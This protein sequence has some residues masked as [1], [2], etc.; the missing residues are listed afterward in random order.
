MNGLDGRVLPPPLPRRRERWWLHALLLGL[1]FCTTTFIGAGFAA[2]FDR[3]LMPRA[4]AGID[5]F[6]RLFAGGLLYSL[7]L[8]AILVSHEMGHYLVCRHYG[9]DASPP[10]FIPVPVVLGT[11]G[12]FIRIREPLRTKRH[13]FDMG[14]AGPIAGFVVTLPI[15]VYG[16]AQTHPAPG[17]GTDAGSTLYQYPLLVTIFQKLLFGT[18]YTSAEVFEHPTFMAGWAGLFVTAFNLIPLSQLDG[19]HA[20]YAVAGRRT[21]LFAFPVLAALLVLGIKFPSWWVLSVLVLIF[22]LKHPP[23][24][25]E[26]APLSPGRKLVA[27]CGLLML[28][29]SFIP[30]PMRQIFSAPRLPKERGGPVVHQLDLHRGAKHAG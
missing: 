5:A 23:V 9:I 6:G 25:D 28:V 19:G 29:L 4:G 11:M 20:L 13:V 21:Q 26:D 10:F 1:T 24:V 12:A 2:N 22:G 17:A 18:T 30:V 15:L 27:A 8:L 16:I 14:I 7:P 3:S